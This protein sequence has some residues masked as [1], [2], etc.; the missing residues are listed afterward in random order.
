MKSL[1]IVLIVAG[2][3]LMIFTGFNMIEREKVID[4]GRV[5]VTKEESHPVRWSPIIGAILLVGG[6]VV[7]LTDKRT[8]A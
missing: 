6:I 2:V 8:T 7:V 5:E 1:G 4:L 3:V